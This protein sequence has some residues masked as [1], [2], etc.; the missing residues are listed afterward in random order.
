MLGFFVI[1]PL[2]WITIPGLL[3]AMW[4]QSR[5]G[6]IYKRYS[7]VG[8]ERRL[9]GAQAARVILDR[10]GCG[11]VDI[12][13]TEGHL[14][15]HYDPAKRAVFLSAEN[16]HSTSVA[17]IGVAAH[18][19]GHAIQHRTA[20]APLAIRMAMVGV[21]SF[22]SRAAWFAIMG[23]LV[24]SSMTQGG[25][26]RTLLI[27][28][29]L[30]F[31]V[32]VLFQVITLPVEYDASRRARLHLEQLGLVTAREM[33]HVGEVLNAAALTYVAA[34]VTSMLQL[35]WLVLRLF[36]LGGMDEDR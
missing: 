8:T 24:L 4:A 19:V 6:S 31:S 2:F 27:A 18:E 12:H 20:Y 9:T 3:L 23:G 11:N 1:D 28:G 32:T 5:L 17:A 14:T 10:S 35:L 25:G 29:I 15:D 36:S 30:L 26:G 33:P 7:R 16:Y 34:M 13:A 21:T 22:A